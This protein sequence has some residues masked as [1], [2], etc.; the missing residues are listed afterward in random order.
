M[1]TEIA[2][3]IRCAHTGEQKAAMVRG[4]IARGIFRAFGAYRVLSIDAW[5]EGSGWTWNNWHGAGYF[6]ARLIDSKPRAVLR[7]MRAL[8]FLSATS[9]GLCSV[10]DDGYNLTICARGT[11]EPLFAIEY[12]AQI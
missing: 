1:H 8:G 11:R 6:P 12:G 10:V 5:R 9:A 3:A 2:A 7:E 4:A